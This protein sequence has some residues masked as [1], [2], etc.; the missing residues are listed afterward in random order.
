MSLERPLPVQDKRR[1]DED[2]CVVWSPHFSRKVSQ[3]S[4][5]LLQRRI[6]CALHVSFG[7]SAS[8]TPELAE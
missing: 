1:T 6:T 4:E 3:E 2:G 7:N 8:R 5:H